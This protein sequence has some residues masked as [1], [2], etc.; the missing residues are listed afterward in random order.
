MPWTPF[1]AGEPDVY[2]WLRAQAAGNGEP[3]GVVAQHLAQLGLGGGLRG[4]A[5]LAGDPLAAGV[6][7]EGGGGNPALPGFVEVQ[8][9]LP[10]A[11][12]CGHDTS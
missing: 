2:R 4:G 1:P 10:A 12:T 5:G 9:A 11:S 8:P 6:E 3:L 7:P